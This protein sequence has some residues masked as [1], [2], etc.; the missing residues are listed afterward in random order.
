MIHDRGRLRSD[1]EDRE[2]YARTKRELMERRWDDMNAYADAES[3]VIGAILA[4]ARVA[5]A[6]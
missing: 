2:L 4:R 1:A 5:R 3:G 6:S